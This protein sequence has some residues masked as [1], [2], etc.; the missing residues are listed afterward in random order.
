MEKFVCTKDG[1][2]GYFKEQVLAGQEFSVLR[3]IRYECVLIVPD[4]RLPNIIASE[5]ELRRLGTLT[6]TPAFGGI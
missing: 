2:V 4:E 3:N 5:K 1:K 6:G